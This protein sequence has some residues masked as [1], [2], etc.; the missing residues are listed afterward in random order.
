MSIVVFCYLNMLCE[1]M[2]RGLVLLD[3]F[4]IGFSLPVGMGF[5]FSSKLLFKY[6]FSD[7]SILIFLN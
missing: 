7:F 5:R 6:V 3:S 4:G 1:V 2:L